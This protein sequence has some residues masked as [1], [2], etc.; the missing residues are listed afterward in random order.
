MPDVETTAADERTAILDAFARWQGH[1]QGGRYVAYG[2]WRVNTGQLTVPAALAG[3]VHR[4][5]PGFGPKVIG[6][7]LAN[8][9]LRDACYLPI[10]NDAVQLAESGARIRSFDHADG[11]SRKLVRLDSKYGAGV[12]TDLAVRR[13][14]LPQAAVPHPRVHASDRDAVHVFIQDELVHGRRFAPLRDS[15]HAHT[16][17]VTPLSRLYAAAGLR[18]MPVADALGAFTAERILG[19]T[20]ELPVVRHAQAILRRNPRVTAGFGHGDLLP[21]N[22]AVTKDGVV[23]LDWET[24][25]YAP[26]GF[27][28]IRL[29][30]KNPRSRAFLSGAQTL[31]R[32]HQRYNFNL[33]DTA[34]LQ[35]SIGLLAAAP[36]RTRP[37]L[38][39]WRHLTPAAD[40]D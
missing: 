22:L 3:L 13:D 36:R 17:L 35:I 40:G 37:A 38:K 5:I 21:S 6:N 19:L 20:S 18:A 31:I 14:L 7:V 16:T 30:R 39:T 2:P 29:W 27:D 15:R 9:A 34:S 11:V 23:F 10:E 4:R 26:V 25:C 24:A 28:M 1:D 12:E 32:W 33:R 8:R